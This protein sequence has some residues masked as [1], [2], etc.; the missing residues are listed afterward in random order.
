MSRGV[1]HQSPLEKADS[2]GNRRILRASAEP[3]LPPR[4]RRRDVRV[5]HSRNLQ[6]GRGWHGQCVGTTVV[7]SQEHVT[8]VCRRGLLCHV[9][10]SSGS[11]EGCAGAALRPM[12]GSARLCT[13]PRFPIWL[14]VIQIFFE[15][16]RNSCSRWQTVS[17]GRSSCLRQR[18]SCRRMI[19]VGN[20]DSAFRPPPASVL[21]RHLH[22]VY[23]ERGKA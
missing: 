1:L 4:H 15:P 21:D 5:I 19:Y 3:D 11:D 13:N 23:T 18:M 12:Y 9:R 10:V 8:R 14:L 17:T 7:R 2:L 22:P 20:L 16:G 6:P